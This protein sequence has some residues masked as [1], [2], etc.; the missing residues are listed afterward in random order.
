MTK[1]Q[2]IMAG[3]VRFHKEIE[4]WF[5]TE[6]EQLKEITKRRNEKD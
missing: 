6:E 2:W 5:V 1:M 3:I 4:S